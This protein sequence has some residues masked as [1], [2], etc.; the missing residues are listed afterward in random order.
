LHHFAVSLDR[1]LLVVL[2]FS[3]CGSKRHKKLKWYYR[4]I[5]N[6]AVHVLGLLTYLAVLGEVRVHHNASPGSSHFDEV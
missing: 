3:S 1:R 5:Q 4:K 6:L 2:L